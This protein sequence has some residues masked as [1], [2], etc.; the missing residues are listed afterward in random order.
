MQKQPEISKHAYQKYLDEGTGDPGLSVES[1]RYWSDYNKLF[2]NPR[3]M[4]QLNDNEISGMRPLETWQAGE[5]LYDNLDRDRETYD[6]DFRH[7]VEECDQSQGL[8]ILTTADDAWGGFAAKYADRL[9]DDFEKSSIWIWAVE[10]TS[11][12]GG[13]WMRRARCEDSANMA[14]LH[15][16]SSEMQASGGSILRDHYR[17]FRIMPRSIL[18]SLT[19]PCKIRET[20]QLT[21]IRPG[22]NQ[23]FKQL[24]SKQ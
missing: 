15:I 20:Y 4:V 3:S 16:H 5:D 8:Q 17:L 23:L 14:L 9:R 10:N 13:G 2:Y 22:T 19:S 1:V 6:Q 11:M 7:F 18:L 24:Q 21:G 12:V